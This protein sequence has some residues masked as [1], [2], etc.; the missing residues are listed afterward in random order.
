[1]YNSDSLS[2]S[3]KGA[4]LHQEDCASCLSALVDMGTV[5]DRKTRHNSILN[6]SC[7]VRA[8][9]SNM[10]WGAIFDPCWCIGGSPGVSV[11]DTGEFNRSEWPGDA[12]R[13]ARRYP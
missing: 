13:E 6:K 8:T 1:M 7:Y 12:F 9:L 10:C 2:V 3:T 11:R 4:I 5:H